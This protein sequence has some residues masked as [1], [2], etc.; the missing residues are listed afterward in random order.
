MTSAELDILSDRF[1]NALS[2]TR[3]E[4]EIEFI[5]TNVE[6]FDC[7]HFRVSQYGTYLINLPIG[8]IPDQH[9]FT[10]EQGL[11]MLDFALR[12]KEL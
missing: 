12:T 7:G 2:T 1:R 3:L 10:A 4:E 5:R 8:V 11:D 6:M 9:Y